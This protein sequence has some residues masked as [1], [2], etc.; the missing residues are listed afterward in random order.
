MDVGAYVPRLALFDVV[1]DLRHGFLQVSVWYGRQIQ[2][3]ISNRLIPRSVLTLHNRGT[4]Q[5]CIFF[6]K[7][8][9]PH[10]PRS[11]VPRILYI[12][13]RLRDSVLPGRLSN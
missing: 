1:I 3:C 8:V 6:L 11:C 4:C 13:L 10:L 5:H 7:N 9:C 12:L 2:K